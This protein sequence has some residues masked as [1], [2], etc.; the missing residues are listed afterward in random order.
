MRAFVVTKYKEPLQEAG[1]A[2][3]LHVVP[4]AC[5]AFDSV[6]AKAAVSQAFFQ[7]QTIALDEALNGG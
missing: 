1:I 3:D 2:W 5:H 6:E 7:A 4:G